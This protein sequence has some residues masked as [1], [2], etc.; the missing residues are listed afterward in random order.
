MKND[1]LIYPDERGELNPYSLICGSCGNARVFYYEETRKVK[2]TFTNGK[3]SFIF[4]RYLKKKSSSD[5]ISIIVAKHM[6]SGAGIIKGLNIKSEKVYCGNCSSEN[7]L[8]YGDV[9]NECQDNSCPGC[10]KCGGAYNEENIVDTC[11]K[12]IN[13]RKDLSEDS[14]M[15]MITL[16]MDLFCDA[17]PLQR[18]REEYGFVG[19]EVKAKAG[20]KLR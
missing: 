9:L 4:G 3:I 20:G 19:E 18:I 12:C 14:A 5:R 11:V 17:C 1:K 8:L 7:I 15:F 10:F 16:D 6:S 2:I 13:Y